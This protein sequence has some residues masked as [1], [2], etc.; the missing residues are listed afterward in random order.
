MHGKVDDGVSNQCDQMFFVINNIKFSVSDFL[1][2][3]R[4]CLLKNINV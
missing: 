3:L 1:F 4:I 2:T